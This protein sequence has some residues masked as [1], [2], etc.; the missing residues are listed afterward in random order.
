MVVRIEDYVASKLIVDDRVD[1]FNKNNPK[2]KTEWR[3]EETKFYSVFVISMRYRDQLE[4]TIKCDF[5]FSVE[6]IIQANYQR[7]YIDWVLED[8]KVKI[9]KEKERTYGKN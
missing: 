5:R 4:R 3:Y 8:L 7:E 9:M 1:E 6:T 2:F